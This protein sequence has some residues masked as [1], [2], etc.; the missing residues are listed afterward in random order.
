MATF[1]V[2]PSNSEKEKAAFQVKITAASLLGLKLRSGDLCTLARQTVGNVDLEEIG[3]AIA[4]EA[5]SGMK[6]NLV[7]TS[8]FLQE[9][10][11]FKLG[12]R[13]VMEKSEQPVEDAEVV[14]M[15]PKVDHLFDG[16]Q[17]SFWQQYARMTVKGM[18][19]YLAKGQ[20][21]SF[22]VGGESEHFEIVDVGTQA[23]AKVNEETS[24]QI[25]RPSSGST[26]GPSKINLVPDGLGGLQKEVGAVQM[27]IDEL[28]R[29]AQENVVPPLQGILIYGAKG[30]GKSHFVDQVTK[31]GW[32]QVVRWTPGSTIK[33]SKRPTIV[34]IHPLDMPSPQDS[35]TALRQLESVF[36]VTRGAP[37]L[38]I[39]ETKHPNDVHP[40]LRSD[41]CFGAELEIPIP[42]AAQ[43]KDILIALWANAAIPRYTVIEQLAERTHGYVAMDLK[44]LLRQLIRVSSESSKR[45][46]TNGDTQA[47]SLPA[48]DTYTITPSAID[49]VLSKIRPSALQE[50]FLETPK[51]RWKDIGGQHS[52]KRALQNAVE[53]PLKLSKQMATLNL[54]PKKGLLMYGPPGC[55]KTLLVRALAREA[56]LNF[57]AVKGAELISMYVG[58]SERAV[59]EI[60]RKARAASP[61]IIF[62]DEIDSIAA[63]GRP[64]SELNV[65]TTL[66]NEMDGF[67]ELRGVFVVAATNKPEVIDGALLR[68]GRF[69]SVVYIG[70]P[71]EEARREILQ[72]QFEKSS[73]Q[74]RAASSVQ[75]DAEYFAQKMEGFSGAEVV[76]IRQNASEFAL[77]E[78]QDSYGYEH[79]EKALQGASKGITREMLDGYERW[80]AARKM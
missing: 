25:M 28:L 66:L 61:S 3:Q 10:Y 73:Y 20:T 51:V 68:P 16:E 58:E 62:F 47:A 40:Y 55:S 34:L 24:F 53:R 22:K 42:T 45:H 5:T 54:P 8:K 6:D 69:D 60:F 67:E 33:P 13:I 2:R 15:V 9:L 56:E 70:L 44:A 80:N 64:G 74:C 32:S 19:D 78:N 37:C 7:Q 52:I 4:F 48:Q 12:D 23:I 36:S 76:A 11:G 49:E 79:M 50:I 39:G 59:R 41:K 35:K 14:K 26:I 1:V 27:L 57:L 30:A 71:D 72:T 43:R 38:I 65:L 75:D 31:S 21:L 17:T 29:P 77:D 46:L 18:H 63:R